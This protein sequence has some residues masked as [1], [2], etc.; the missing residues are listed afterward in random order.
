MCL[1]TGTRLPD[2]RLAEEILRYLTD[3]DLSICKDSSQVDYST[4]ITIALPGK[5]IA[6]E[7]RTNTGRPQLATPRTIVPEAWGRLNWTVAAP[8]M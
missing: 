4:E 5:E 8:D 1:L 6:A 7:I 2:T 3:S